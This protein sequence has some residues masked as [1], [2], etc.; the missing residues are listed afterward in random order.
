MF[1]E[2]T[3]VWVLGVDCTRSS[4]VI[5]NLNMS[6]HCF[7]RRPCHPFS[8]VKELGR[9]CFRKCCNIESRRLANYSHQHFLPRHCWLPSTFRARNLIAHLQ[10]KQ[11][12]AAGRSLQMC[13]CPHDQK[14]IECSTTPKHKH[15]IKVYILLCSNTFNFGPMV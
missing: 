9:C 14:P 2:Q 10:P 5:D 3:S 8:L 6:I 12:V 4:Q 13:F 15:R 1:R 7:C 11:V